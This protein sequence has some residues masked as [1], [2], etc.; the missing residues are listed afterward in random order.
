MKKYRIEIEVE[1]ADILDYKDG[2]QTACELQTL[3][4]FETYGQIKVKIIR[5][6]EVAE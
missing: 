5:A 3:I 1:T 2:I 6:E 4:E